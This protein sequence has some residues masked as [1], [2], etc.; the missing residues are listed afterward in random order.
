[1]KEKDYYT[2]FV[3]LCLK[4]CL[5]DDYGDKSKVRQHNR[6]MNKLLKLQKEMEE[7][8]C[9]EILDKLLIHDDDRVK[10]SAGTFAVDFPSHREKSIIAINDVA[11]KS[12]DKMLSFD[13]YMVLGVKGLREEAQKLDSLEKDN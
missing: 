3:D 11:K 4:R 1:M 9:S 12:K 5:T 6:S 7:K 13:A 10:L 2:L 8:D